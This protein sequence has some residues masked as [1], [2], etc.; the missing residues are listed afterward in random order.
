[1]RPAPAVPGSPAKASS[2][3]GSPACPSP[4]FGVVGVVASPGGCGAG[5][6]DVVAGGATEGSGAAGCTAA[7]VS[8][9][10]IATMSSP[11]TPG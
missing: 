9:S 11:R 5:V 1:L 6:V 8:V 10:W 4:G 2:G 3:V 7:G